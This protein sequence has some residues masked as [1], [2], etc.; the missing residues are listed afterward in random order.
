MYTE[1]N[2]CRSTANIFQFISNWCVMKMI[3]IRRISPYMSETLGRINE[4]TQNGIQVVR[5]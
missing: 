3:V 4:I 2:V 5:F 1:K